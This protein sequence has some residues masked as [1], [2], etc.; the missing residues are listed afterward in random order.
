MEVVQEPRASWVAHGVLDRFA[1]GLPERLGA[2]VEGRFGPVRF[3][4]GDTLLFGVIELDEAPLQAVFSQGRDG[5]RLPVEVMTRD[6]YDAL[7]GCLAAQGFAYLVRVW[8]FIPDIIGEQA[9]HERYRL[10]N[11]A[12]Q[13]AFRAAGR[14]LTGDVPAATGIGLDARR[15]QIYFIASRVRALPVENP[16]Q[17]SAFHYPSQYGRKSPDLRAR[18]RAAARFGTVAADLGDGQHR[19]PRVGPFGRCRRPGR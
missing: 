18:G 1:T 4:R 2:R 5:G 11:S 3:V 19:R 14:A 15:L 10:F 16:R 13:E 9:G 8:N 17:V 7:F 6:A 12:R